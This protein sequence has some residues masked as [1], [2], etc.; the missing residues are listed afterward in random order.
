MLSA[1]QHSVMCAIAI[2][3]EV[4]RT[5]WVC[6]VESKLPMKVTFEL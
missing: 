1:S 5:D 2:N 4:E 3:M 6:L